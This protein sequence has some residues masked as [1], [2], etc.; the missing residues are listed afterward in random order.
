MSNV[1]VLKKSGLS[2]LYGTLTQRN[3]RWAGHVDRLPNTRIPKQVLYS[4]LVEGSRGIGRPWLR[5]KD[6]IKR[7]LKDKDIY[8]GPR[9]SS[10]KT[11]PDG[12]K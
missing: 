4:Q 8:L 1:K 11:D 7:N 2:S 3:L 5:F 9:R 6:I 12:V 10:L